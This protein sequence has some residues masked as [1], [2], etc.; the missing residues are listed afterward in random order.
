MVPSTKV[1]S[2]GNNKKKGKKKGEGRKER[3]WTVVGVGEKKKIATLGENGQGKTERAWHR[4]E[5]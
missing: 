5:K 4:E 1:F 3:D 2:Q